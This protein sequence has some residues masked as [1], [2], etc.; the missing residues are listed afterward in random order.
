MWVSEIREPR[1]EK[2][3][4]LGSFP[5][6]EM[7]ARAHDAAAFAL[8]GK[9]ANF[10]F[11]ESINSL[12]CPATSSTTDIQAAAL[13]AAYSS[14]EDQEKQ[15]GPHLCSNINSDDN[16]IGL[17]ESEPTIHNQ[18]ESTDIVETGSKNN[19]IV[20]SWLD[21]PNL[22]MNIAD[23]VQIGSSLLFHN[24]FTGKEDQDHH[25]TSLW[26]FT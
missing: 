10:N 7:A 19:E 26:D 9:S 1:K 12:P 23:G 14:S 16:S 4:W 2:R 3:I 25:F 18:S 24:P 22:L 11:P 21:W 17:H 5:T 8:R 13:Q 15:E 6:P 20:D